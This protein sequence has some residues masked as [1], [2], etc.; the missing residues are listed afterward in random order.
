MAVTLQ[1]QYEKWL[2]KKIDTPKDAATPLVTAYLKLHKNDWAKA[3]SRANRVNGT[4]YNLRRFGEWKNGHYP[5]PKEVKK[6][7]QTA[8]LVSRFGKQG[9][10]LLKLLDI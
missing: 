7:M 5:I 4:R 8:V 3:L 2:A 1:K 9:H 10:Q 6:H